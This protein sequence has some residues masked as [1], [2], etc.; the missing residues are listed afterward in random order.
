LGSVFQ[1][2]KRDTRHVLNLES[3]SLVPLSPSNKLQDWREAN[4]NAQETIRKGMNTVNAAIF[5]PHTSITHPLT[6]A[7]KAL[8]HMYKV[9]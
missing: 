4:E 2:A 8:L 5:T 1:Q 7:I 6:A 9:A 3:Q